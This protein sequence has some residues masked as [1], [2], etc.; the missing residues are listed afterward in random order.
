MQTEL[1][2]PA[3]LPPLPE[4]TSV[5]RQTDSRLAMRL[6]FPGAFF[7]ALANSGV[8]WAWDGIGNVVVAKGHPSEVLHT[9]AR[10]GSDAGALPAEAGAG[11]S[12]TPTPIAGVA[13]PVST[14][15]DLTVRKTALP[16]SSEDPLTWLTSTG[17][18]ELDRLREWVVT[19]G[20]T[21][22]H[23]TLWAHFAQA[24][25]WSL[26]AA[27]SEAVVEPSEAATSNPS[28]EA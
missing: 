11:P 20:M 15:P 25:G 14:I 19:Q 24:M 1:T 10:S 2:I 7:T 12:G 22:P 3:A 17:A 27:E 28:K 16:S 6:G 8:L 26:P 18:M 5:K 21:T 13:E 23:S 4:G 9:V